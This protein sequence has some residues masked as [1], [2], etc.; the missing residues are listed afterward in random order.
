MK[1]LLRSPLF[2][3]IAGW[4]IWAW[5][6]LVGR[7]VRWR[8]EGVDAFR[9]HLST[10][11]AGV[12]LACWHETILLM[13]SGWNRQIRRWPERRQRTAMMISLS[14]DGA[15]VAETLRHFDLDVVRGSKSN[16][17]KADK[18]KGGVR[19]IAEASKR[20]REGGIVCM[21]PDGPRGPYRAASAGAV[22]LAQRS[23]AVVI[24]YALASKP[25]PRLDT[26]DRFM[27][28]LPFT[29]GGIVFGAPI[30]CGRDDDTEALRER[31]QTGLDEATRRAE[32]LAGYKDPPAPA[33]AAD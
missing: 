25:A 16:K 14:P 31:L 2:V 20:L 8:I 10:G 28:P 23:G 12:V 33:G 24:P 17:K 5:M 9:N 13:P 27:I 19:A 15:P 18:D 7:T 30:T 4:I 3:A 29:R 32:T 21:T 6:A 1:S 22:T 11:G 26:W